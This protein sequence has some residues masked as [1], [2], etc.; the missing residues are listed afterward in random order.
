MWVLHT[1]TRPSL[2]HPPTHPHPPAHPHPPTH[3]HTNPPL[4]L[5]PPTHPHTNPPPHLHPPCWPCETA[6]ARRPGTHRRG[7]RPP[8][9]APARRPR[10]PRLPPQ[11]GRWLACPPPT[12]RQGATPSGPR[13]WGLVGLCVWGGRGGRTLACAHTSDADPTYPNPTHPTHLPPPIGVVGARVAN[14]PHKRACL[15]VQARQQVVAAPPQ[16]GSRGARCPRA[17]IALG[18]VQRPPGKEG[19]GGGEGE[20]ASGGG[21]GRECRW[22]ESAPAPRARTRHSHWSLRWSPA[23]W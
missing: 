14:L 8:P 12:R 3:P 16:R 19:E 5:H 9:A 6:H 22:E 21:G 23:S 4:H 18:K 20:A 1:R 15:L 11:P 10:A 2:T 13:A 17:R 7:G